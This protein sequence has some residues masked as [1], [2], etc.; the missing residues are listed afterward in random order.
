VINGFQDSVT[1]S[2][3]TLNEVGTLPITFY[4]N[5][6][7]D[8]NPSNDTL[9]DSITVNPTGI[10]EHKQ[11]TP[12]KKFRVSPTIASNYVNV[13]GLEAWLDIYDVTGR[14]V[15]KYEV[16]KEGTNINTS[17]LNSGV[18]FLKPKDPESSVEKI[19]LI[20]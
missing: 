17:E 6:V 12:R 14:R 15:G 2:P 1:F 5:L 7:G 4:S 16:K 9:K 19:L 20:R 18:Y 13:S 11:E 3:C 8:I 10:S